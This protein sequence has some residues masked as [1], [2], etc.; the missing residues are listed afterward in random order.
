MGL[1]GGSGA[2]QKSTLGDVEAGGARRLGW[3]EVPVSGQMKR[4]AG[5]AGGR[6]RHMTGIEGW[7]L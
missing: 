3:C 4:S 7:Q 2:G 6:G 5:L 1:V